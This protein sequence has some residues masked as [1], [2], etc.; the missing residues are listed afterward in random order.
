[1]PTVWRGR[2]GRQTRRITLPDSVSARQST[3]AANGSTR[4]GRMLGSFV[5][6]VKFDLAAPAGQSGPPTIVP[7]R[8]R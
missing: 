6:I 4:G 7:P 1:M 5:G 8:Q 2:V 3:S